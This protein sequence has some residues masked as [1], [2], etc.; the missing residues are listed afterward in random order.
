M[1]VHKGTYVEIIELYIVYQINN[2]WVLLVIDPSEIIWEKR[3][4]MR[5]LDSWLFSWRT[6]YFGNCLIATKISGFW[7]SITYT[8][9]Q[10]GHLFG[11]LGLCPENNQ[12]AQSKPQR[13]AWIFRKPNSPV[14]GIP[15]TGPTGPL[16]GSTEGTRDSGEVF[17]CKKKRLKK[18]PI[19]I[20][21]WWFQIFLNVHPET[22]GKFE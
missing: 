7:T 17:C 15:R 2:W 10:I 3:L 4:A 19:T 6:S 1:V 5:L 16:V 11:W 18:I 9:Q 8:F 14:V 22:L 20:S 12:V 21:R 13:C